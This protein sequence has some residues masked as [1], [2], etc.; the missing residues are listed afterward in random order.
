MIDITTLKEYKTNTDNTSH[1]NNTDQTV[2]KMGP[3]LEL[4]LMNKMKNDNVTC[5]LCEWL[6]RGLFRIPDYIY[7]DEEKYQSIPIKWKFTLLITITIIIVEFIL[8]QLLYN[9]IFCHF[10][11]TNIDPAQPELIDIRIRKTIFYFCDFCISVPILYYF[12]NP[13][14]VNRLIPHWMY[15]KVVRDDENCCKYVLNNI[16]YGIPSVENIAS[17]EIIDYLLNNKK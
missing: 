14:I 11:F 5:N 10:E 16:L 6:E 15:T 17:H 7:V 13:F 3:D 1:E 2:I 9:N 4:D 12:V 8:F